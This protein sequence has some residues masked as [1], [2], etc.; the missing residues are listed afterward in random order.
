[1]VVVL[2]VALGRTSE[3]GRI[4]HPAV[5][6]H[7]VL[8]PSYSVSWHV[9][10]AFE[11]PKH[12]TAPSAPPASARRPHHRPAPPPPPPATA[13]RKGTSPRAQLTVQRVVLAAFKA[14][15]KK[16]GDAS[17]N[18]DERLLLWAL[19][20]AEV[21][22]DGIASLADGD[23]RAVESL[24]TEGGRW[25]PLARSAL[26]LWRKDLS[27]KGSALRVEYRA[28]VAAAARRAKASA[29]RARV[30]L[31]A[32]MAGKEVRELS[33]QRKRSAV[34]RE[35]LRDHLTAQAARDA[36]AILHSPAT[37][38]EAFELASGVA[39]R[40]VERGHVLSHWALEC[41]RAKSYERKLQAAHSGSAAYV[42][43]FKV[44]QGQLLTAREL[45]L[46]RAAATGESP[47]GV[48]TLLSA[49]AQRKV[50]RWVDEGGESA[51]AARLVAARLAGQAQP[52][53]GI[54]DAVDQGGSGSAADRVAAGRPTP[55]MTPPP[56]R[57]PPQPPATER[58]LHRRPP[59]RGRDS[60]SLQNAKSRWLDLLEKE[61][62]GCRSR[63]A[64][65]Y[66]H[67]GV[68]AGG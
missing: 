62:R 56:H 5:S 8:D 60:A 35:A 44:E 66:V 19:Q 49:E 7:M 4:S 10:N 61:E 26:A 28:L 53:V 64:A 45:T 12:R 16:D 65:P 68:Q 51:L 11:A 30:H 52:L 37:F 24:L 38:D 18:E 2:F 57:V 54:S 17:L 20:K 39:M 22:P 9:R 36:H 58:G 55:P 48:P 29:L 15:A 1:M 42:A 14:R 21:S 6:A 33:A 50:R 32:E 25:Q 46:L 43:K 40:Q 31:A 47:P 13:R 27:R 3:L 59:L 63:W 23:R 67:E 41:L 34:Q